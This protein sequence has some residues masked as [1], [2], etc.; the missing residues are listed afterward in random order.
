MTQKTFSYYSCIQHQSGAG[1]MSTDEKYEYK[2][3][4][5]KKVSTQLDTFLG[6]GYHYKIQRLGLLEEEKSF[7]NRIKEYFTGEHQKPSYSK[8]LPFPE[9]Y[10]IDSE[11]E[12]PEFKGGHLLTTDN[13]QAKI[14]ISEALHCY[15]DWKVQ[16]SLTSTFLVGAS[17]A[18]LKVAESLNWVSLLTSFFCMPGYFVIMIPLSLIIL[19]TSLPI[20]KKACNELNIFQGKK[21]GI[22]P[23]GIHCIGALTVFIPFIVSIFVVIYPTPFLLAGITTPFFIP[24]LISLFALLAGFVI[25]AALSNP[26]TKEKVEKF[27]M[28]YTNYNRFVK[29]ECKENS[30][31]TVMWKPVKKIKEDDILHISPGEKVPIRSTI[32]RFEEKETISCNIDNKDVTGITGEFACQLGRELY[33]GAKNCSNFTITVK[34]L[35]N[36]YKLIKNKKDEQNRSL[37]ETED[38]RSGLIKIWPN[39]FCISLLIGVAI[40]VTVGIC[41]DLPFFILVHIITCLNAF[42]PTTIFVGFYS[43]IFH[44]SSVLRKFGLKF[45]EIHSLHLPITNRTGKKTICFDWTGTLAKNNSLYAEDVKIGS[46]LNADIVSKILSLESTQ[47]SQHA[48]SISKELLKKMNDKEFTYKQQK[49]TIIENEGY[50]SGVHGRYE[51][52]T[53][54]IIGNSKYMRN[55]G[56][57]CIA[58]NSNKQQSYVAKKITGEDNFKQ[59]ADTSF[60]FT[61]EDT[62]VIT[63]ELIIYCIKNNIKVQ[64]IS[65]A[66]SLT[67][68]SPYNKLFRSVFKKLP[69]SCTAKKNSNISEFHKLWFPSPLCSQSPAEKGKF[70]KNLKKDAITVWAVGDGSNDQSMIHEA[71]CGFS[72]G[73]NPKLRSAEFELPRLED[74]LSLIRSEECVRNT[75]N[76]TMN[77]LFLIFLIELICSTGIFILVGISM[78]PTLLVAGCNIGILIFTIINIFIL[79]RR[80]GY[81]IQKIFEEVTKEAQGTQNG[82]MPASNLLCQDTMQQIQHNNIGNGIEP[83]NVKGLA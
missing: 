52:G 37:A 62:K 63:E 56:I 73:G 74:L 43:S 64:I 47:E 80:L 6:N 42:C 72:I 18:L 48:M 55:H 35:K 75:Q 40:V 38:K 76:I 81:N 33:F 59:L 77:L 22:Q 20:L 9:V 36:G 3:I 49:A 53:E 83:V 11:S 78:S 26:G 29:V 5:E 61:P 17:I 60:S 34:A 39:L 68:E 15:E 46:K 67:L 25:D 19:Y 71:E 50:G 70:V 58:K 31:K 82:I 66:D 4:G 12:I 32:I 16:S 65:G 30:Q 21:N 2:E 28:E 69:Q 51:D 54:I 57:D 41:L 8:K 1:G 10:R 44:A 13:Y 79:N 23:P 24:S 27:N 45:R 7:F 14:E